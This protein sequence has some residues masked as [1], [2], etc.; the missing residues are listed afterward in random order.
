MHRPRFSYVLSA[1][2]FLAL[3]SWMSVRS[4]DNMIGQIYYGS[5]HGFF[6][7]AFHLKGREPE[8]PFKT[9]VAVYYSKATASSFKEPDKYGSLVVAWRRM[10]GQ[11]GLANEIVDEKGLTGG[12]LA[13]YTVLVLPFATHL[14]DREA[15]AIK[16]FVSQEGHGL[17]LSGA[18]G[19]RRENGDWREISLAAEIIGGDDMKEVAPRTG[20]VAFMVLDGRNPLSA[21]IP[22]GLRMGVNTYDR[23]V[24]AR[25][26]E[27]RSEAAGYWEEDGR[28]RPSDARA[29]MASGK[30]RGGRFVW[31]GFTLGS[32]IDPFG[33]KAGEILARNMLAYAAFSPIFAKE[34]WPS[35]KQAA[36]VFA[37]ETDANFQ[38][39]GAAALFSRKRVPCT[40]F[41]AP[42]DAG[43][44]PAAF[45]AIAS[46][47]LFEVGL[48]GTPAYRGASS[49]KRRQLLRDGK[50]AL[51]ALAGRSVAGFSPPEGLY[52]KDTLKTL[53]GS[54][55]SYL[56][57]D[58]ADGGP[59]S[60]VQAR[61]PKL[62]SIGRSLQLLIK[63]PHAGPEGEAPSFERLK[64]DF[65]AAYRVGGF[66]TLS[67]PPALLK[68]KARADALSRFLDYVKTKNVWLA[69][70][71]EVADWSSRWTLIDVDSSK[72]SKVRSNL[73]V[74]N[75]S[76]GE[77]ESLRLNAYLLDDGAD[78]AASSEKLGGN[79]NVVSQH[80]GKAT[81]E[82]RGL[83][84]EGLV[85]FV[86][87]NAT[88]GK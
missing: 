83:R 20:G 31:T 19:S 4:Y 74:T 17:I 85:F 77:V 56:T 53:L 10:L 33:V 22:P 51:E 63:F 75:S 32:S 41:F 21:N 38:D 6:A 47:P 36:V 14:S 15:A 80:D 40:F 61:R 81:L 62:L 39:S 45:K 58:A 9:K 7:N 66:Y 25:I 82:I 88:L 59:P 24:S 28:A 87:R 13:S 71:G 1:M 79:I 23:P 70:Y 11:Q 48:R 8:T 84:G 29:G 67:L 73:I 65:D 26:L 16:D 78:I 27:P 52:D 86:D 57:G 5:L 60:V 68:D 35:G 3:A 34:S 2:T 76:P 49:E 55:Y 46:D 12:A 50:K 42:E 44:S 54:G 69:N 72:T 30:Y 18:A 64:Q 43:R 37:Q